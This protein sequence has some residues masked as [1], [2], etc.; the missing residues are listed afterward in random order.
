MKNDKFQR[1][2]CQRNDNVWNDKLVKRSW[3][4]SGELPLLCLSFEGEGRRR[5]RAIREKEF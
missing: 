5:E 3:T 2:K 4:R 1:H